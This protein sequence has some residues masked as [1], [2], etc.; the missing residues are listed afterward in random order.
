MDGLRIQGIN[1][2]T[3]NI[4]RLGCW[5]LATDRLIIGMR[6]WTGRELE[7]GSLDGNRWVFRDRQSLDGGG[8]GLLA[9][10]GQ[11]A[12]CVDPESLDGERRSGSGD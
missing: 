2:D 3:G 10:F 9:T 12:G 4:G 11:W 6:R 5:A 1:Q 8:N 7:T